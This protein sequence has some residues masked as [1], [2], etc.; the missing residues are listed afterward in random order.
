MLISAKPVCTVMLRI[1]DFDILLFGVSVNH[2]PVEV[3]DLACGDT[4]PDEILA[5]ADG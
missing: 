2:G 1:R 5:G 3:Y 4:I